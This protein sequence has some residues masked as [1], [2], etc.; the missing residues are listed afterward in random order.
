MSILNF[1]ANK[2]ELCKTDACIKKTMDF[3]KII[4]SYKDFDCPMFDVSFGDTSISFYFFD[5]DNT[6]PCIYMDMLHRKQA[7]ED[8]INQLI[9]KAIHADELPKET[10]IEIHFDAERSKYDYY[11]LRYY[12]KTEHKKCASIYFE[13]IQNQCSA[14]G[15]SF[16]IDA[17]A[18]RISFKLK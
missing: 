3:I 12:L 13:N 7:D 1:F 6:S 5:S 17:R 16:K 14:L 18:R 2:K 15:F 11:V 4:H 8:A 10:K 9:G